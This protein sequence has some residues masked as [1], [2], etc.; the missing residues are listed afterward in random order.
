MML[1]GTDDPGAIWRSLLWPCYDVIII[2]LS[3]VLYD[4]L[5]SA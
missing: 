2:L 4:F 1:V 5:L 3:W